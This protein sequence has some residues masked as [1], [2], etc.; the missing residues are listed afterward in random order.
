MS[1]NAYIAGGYW[2]ICDV[3]GQKY[4]A[5]ET[6]MRWDGLRVCHKDFE[7]RHPQEQVRGR[8]DRQRVPNARPEQPDRFI[9]TEVSRDDL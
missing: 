3:C 6:R 8:V 9:E 1:E 2:V 4:R 7:V 5:S